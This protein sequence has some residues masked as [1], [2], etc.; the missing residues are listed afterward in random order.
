MLGF[1]SCQTMPLPFSHPGQDHAGIASAFVA[2]GFLFMCEMQSDWDMR[3]T[4]G[5]LRSSAFLAFRTRRVESAAQWE[6]CVD[7]F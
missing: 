2:A 1:D 5:E 3:L 7:D 6:M 4:N